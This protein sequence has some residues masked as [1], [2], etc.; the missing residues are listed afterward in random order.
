[1]GRA[2]WTTLPLPEAGTVAVHLSPGGAVEGIVRGARAGFSLRV[3]SQ[4][5]SAGWRTLDEHRFA[6]ERFELG[7]LPPEPLRLEVRTDDGRRGAAELRVAPGETRAVE[8]A[9]R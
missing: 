7:D 1:G 8:I 3:S 5:A 4:P 9:L 6:G 2:G